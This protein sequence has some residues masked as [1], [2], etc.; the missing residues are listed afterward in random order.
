MHIY[1][2]YLLFLTLKFVYMLF[3]NYFVGVPWR[4]V[5]L[6]QSLSYVHTSSVH[7]NNGYHLMVISRS[8]RAQASDH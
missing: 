4:R 8:S 1:S 3:K 7:V 2:I 5:T 6:S